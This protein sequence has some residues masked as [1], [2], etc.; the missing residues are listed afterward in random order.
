MKLFC[1]SFY[2]A[3]NITAYMALNGRIIGE[4]WI[5]EDKEAVVA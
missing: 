4:Q 3:I 2:D 5:G 1:G